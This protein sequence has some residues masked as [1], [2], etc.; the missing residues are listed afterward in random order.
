MIQFSRSQQ[1]LVKPI[2]LPQYSHMFCINCVTKIRENQDGPIHCPNCFTP[3]KG[4]DL[5]TNFALKTMVAKVL[6]QCS[7]CRHKDELETL[8]KHKCPEEEITCSNEGCSLRT[9]RKEKEMHAE[10]CLCRVIQGSLCHHRTTLMDRKILT[11]YCCPE[12]KTTFPFRWK[13]RLKRQ[14]RNH[15]EQQI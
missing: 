2:I 7:R 11:D 12:G 4:G 15:G 14:D 10:D 5:H 9:K 1:I 13:L 6:T 3:N 8:L